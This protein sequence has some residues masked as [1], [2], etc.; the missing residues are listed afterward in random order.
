MMRM[1]HRLVQTQS[2]RLMLTQRMQQAIQ[3]LQLSGL[4]LDQDV[5]QEL[6]A[7][8]VL[9]QKQQT[10]EPPAE[11]NQESSNGEEQVDDVAF[12]LDDFATRLGAYGRT[13][14]DLSRNRDADNAHAV[15]G[16]LLT[17]KQ[18]DTAGE[19]E[20]A[21]GHQHM[22]RMGNQGDREEQEPEQE[23]DPVLALI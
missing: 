7:N 23:C 18:G 6:E 5:Q 2:Q 21:Q 3:I 8:P 11:D 13:G 14:P 15:E 19:D 16:D 12:D 4:E 10:L 17:A 1:E 22:A 20:H 9:E